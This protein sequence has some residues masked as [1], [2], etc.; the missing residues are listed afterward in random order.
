LGEVEVA[1]AAGLAVAAGVGA[2]GGLDVVAGEGEVGGG[3]GE[4]EA[5]DAGLGEGLQFVGLADA[6]LVAVAPEADVGEL[7]VES[8]EEAVV[9]AVEVG[10]GGEAVGGFLAVGEHGVDAE[11]FVAVVDRAVAVLA[12]REEGVV[13]FEPAGAGLDAV[14]VAVEEHRGAADAGGFESVAVKVEGEGVLARGG[15][16]AGGEVTV[17]AT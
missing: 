2:G 1:G 5:D 16:A 8:A 13:A 11:E 7:G 17:V 10:Q 15:V 14:A 9:V 6:V 12:E 3:A 4:A